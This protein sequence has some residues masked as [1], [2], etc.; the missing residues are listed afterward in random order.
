MSVIGFNIAKIDAEKKNA[1]KGKVNV[2]SNVTIK[3]VEV[4]NVSL[5]NADE[6]VLDFNFEFKT[7]YSPEVGHIL[8]AGNLLFLT[9]SE[10]AIRISK[11]WNKTKKLD[12]SVMRPVFNTVLARGNIQA[13]IISKDLNLPAPIQLPRMKDN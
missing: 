2:E 9:K 3:K 6:K 12:Q 5:G 13:M 8:I 1:P 4:S 7:N 10:D 11:E